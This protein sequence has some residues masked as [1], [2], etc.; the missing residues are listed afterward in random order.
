MSNKHN[1]TP[2]T[3][4]IT[5]SYQDNTAAGLSANCIIARVQKSD[6]AD[7]TKLK[8]ISAVARLTEIFGKPLT[9]IPL[10][11]AVITAGL[12]DKNLQRLPCR[13][14]TARQYARRILAAVQLAT[15]EAAERAVRR[16]QEDDWS[17]LRTALEKVAQGPGTRP[18][19]TFNSKR[20]ISV[21][22][23]I[24]IAR[25]IGM[26]VVDLNEDGALTLFRAAPSQNVRNAI[27][28][29]IQLFLALRSAS[30][31]EFTHLLPPIERF[32]RPRL[33][34]RGQEIP[35][36]LSD[37]LE[38][39]VDLV[40]RGTRCEATGVYFD[41][42]VPKPYRYAGLKVI[43]TYLDTGANPVTIIDAFD[44]QM[45]LNS[46]ATWARY[47]AEGD[48]RQIAAQ[49]AEG[50]LWRTKA[51]LERNGYAGDHIPDLIAS[52]AWIQE[53]LDRD[54]EMTE[55]AE[56]FCRRLLRE[57]RMRLIFLSEHIRFR[58]LAM[59]LMQGSTRP[60]NGRAL[61]QV[62]ALGGLAAVAALETDAA[63][64]RI[65]NI[66]GIPLYGPDAW[67]RPP[68]SSCP[69]AHLDI[70]GTH[71][72]NGRSIHGVLSASSKLRGLATLEWFIKEIRPLFLDG[73][74]SKWLFPSVEDPSQ[75]LPYNTFLRWWT[76]Q[77]DG[78]ELHGMT[79][80]FFRHGQATILAARH[81]GNWGLVSQRIGDSEAVTRKRY[82][83]VDT[84]E[85]MR[86]GQNS[87]I[88]EF[89]GI[90][91]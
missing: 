14:P 33:I 32:Q 26:G 62:R 30:W 54:G 39:M 72:K 4:K 8:Y 63:P 78:T 13:L 34:H 81:P 56:S 17:E 79:P 74:E 76:A 31:C 90:A 49:T 10:D 1:F 45:L 52:N 6:K 84:A 2:A 53:K 11:I 46:L 48:P 12:T 3:T 25:K 42:K 50:Y 27:F 24:N 85:L 7:S 47:E 89:E 28:G 16:A 75:P 15:G 71:T 21:D 38:V 51:L 60:L 22:C 58:R 59:E 65:S 77:V 19:T 5:P 36:H 68:T 61:E 69:D 35:A 20:L 57:K 86:Q 70:P 43:R 9:D 83:F 73:R 18:L 80:H 67:Y 44:R 82:A 23:L 55:K 37:E 29:A 66:L 41:A 87:L 91:Q 88:A 40:S 64:A